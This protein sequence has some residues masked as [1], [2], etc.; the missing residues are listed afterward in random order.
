MAK[1]FLRDVPCCR[2]QSYGTGSNIDYS[3]ISYSFM[4]MIQ[5]IL[6]LRV[7]NIKKIRMVVTRV[8][9]CLPELKR[10]CY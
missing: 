3:L 9:I 2:S 8:N 7:F 6:D 5:I 10:C 1:Y 4:K